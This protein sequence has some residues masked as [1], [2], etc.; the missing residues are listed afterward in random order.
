MENVTFKHFST[1]TQLVEALEAQ[2][3]VEEIVA[4]QEFAAPVD[5]ADFLV[6]LG[7]E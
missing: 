7:I 3:L 2:G 1:E 6:E 5:L 4:E